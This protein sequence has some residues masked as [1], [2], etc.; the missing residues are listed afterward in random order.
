M[1]A[2]ELTEKS[3]QLLCDI[4]DVLANNQAH[5]PT[6]PKWYY[7]LSSAKRLVSLVGLISRGNDVPRFILMG[8]LNLFTKRLADMGYPPLTPEERKMFDA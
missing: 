4:V 5:S 3:K 8:E 1:S 6:P 2:K 7:A